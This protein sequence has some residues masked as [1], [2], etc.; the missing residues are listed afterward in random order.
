M[1]KSLGRL[2]LSMA[3]TTI[4][5]ACASALAVDDS[6][7]FIEGLQQRNYLD[8]AA[9]FLEGMAA[10]PNLSADAKRALPYQQALFLIDGAVSIRDP[11]VRDAQLDD[12]QAKLKNFLAANPDHELASQARARLANVL[13]YRAAALWSQADDRGADRAKLRAGAQ[14]MYADACKTLIDSAKRLRAKLDALPKDEQSAKTREEIGSQWLGNLLDAARTTFD[15]ALTAEPKSDQ[16]RKWLTD[17]ADQFSAIY[18]KYPK[19]LAGSYARYYEGNCYEELGDRAKALS[20]YDDLMVD[21][22]DAD[23]AFRPLKTQATRRAQ[24]LWL[25]DKDYGTLVEKTLSWAKSARGEEANETDWLAVKLNAATALAE[26]SAK[27]PKSDPKGTM[28]LR[29][30]RQLA[31][32]VAKSKNT[33]LQAEARQLLTRIERGSFN[34]QAVGAPAGRDTVQFV[35][36]TSSNSAAVNGTKPA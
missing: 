22:L 29:E 11:Q 3:A 10:D 25:D 9:E 19:R 34:A 12:A 24:R 21:S 15:M 7:K 2:F 23:V 31:G 32:E 17:S 36:E 20:A 28:S 30:A 26:Q 18:Q 33:A 8:T 13:R 27:P 5:Y 16:K 4:A 14:A 35:S 1:R 6:Q